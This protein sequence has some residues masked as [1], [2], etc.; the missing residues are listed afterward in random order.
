M[1]QYVNLSIW[2]LCNGVYKYA[3][4]VYT[5]L[6]IL[7]ATE[8]KN[9]TATDEHSSFFISRSRPPALACLCFAV[10]FPDDFD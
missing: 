7:A 8:M 3:R 4:R 1:E 9:A 5:L 10:F 2:L 6:W